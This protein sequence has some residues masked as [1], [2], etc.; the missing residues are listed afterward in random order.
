[1]VLH[2]CGPGSRITLAD[3]S[4]ALELDE[5]DAWSLYARGVARRK[6]GDIAE[7]DRDIAEAKKLWPNVA[8]AV[9]KDG[10]E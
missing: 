3:L 2:T 9:A 10:I 4:R 5:G 8:A 1:V 7:G 6:A